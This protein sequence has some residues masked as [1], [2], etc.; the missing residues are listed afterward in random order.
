MFALRSLVED[1]WMRPGRRRLLVIRGRSP[2]QLMR[3]AFRVE[4]ANRR[5]HRLA[6]KQ[7]LRSRLRTRFDAIFTLNKARLAR[8]CL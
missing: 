2:Q 3:Q 5:D 7:G 8:A 4:Q 1:F 6:L